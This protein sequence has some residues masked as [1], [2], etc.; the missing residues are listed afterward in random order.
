MVDG[1]FTRVFDQS[2][3]IVSGV[4]WAIESEF[5]DGGFGGG[6]GCP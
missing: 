3:D 4:V 2:L 1:D 6:A 5:Y